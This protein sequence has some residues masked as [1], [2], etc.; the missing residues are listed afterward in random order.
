MVNIKL[1]LG[2]IVELNF[3]DPQYTVGIY[4]Y[5][6]A[7][8]VFSAIVFSITAASLCTVLYVVGMFP[9]GREEQLYQTF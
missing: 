5:D 3:V 8:F 7:L 9:S 6:N 2:D 1:V 4:N